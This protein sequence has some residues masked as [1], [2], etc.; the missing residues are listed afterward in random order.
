MLTEAKLT[1]TA[2]AEHVIYLFREKTPFS[3]LLRGPAAKW[4]GSPFHDAM[5]WD[6]ERALFLTRFSDAGSKFRHRMEVEHC[7]RADGK[8]IWNFFHRIKKTVDKGWPDDMFGVA[9]GDQT[10]EHAAQARQRRQRY[11]DCT[12]RR[13]RP[14]YLQWKA[15]E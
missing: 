6:D 12:L 1:D 9:L 11:I 5:H 3:P 8:E 14:R 15:H 10:A 4:Y 7:I 2:D 13:L